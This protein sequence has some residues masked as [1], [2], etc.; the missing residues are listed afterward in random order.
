M[1]VPLGTPPR[2]PESFL[3]GERLPR[4]LDT[5]CPGPCLFREAK[6]ALRRASWGA[7]WSARLDHAQVV[8]QRYAW[9]MGNIGIDIQR[10]ACYQ[11]VNCNGLLSVSEFSRCRTGRVP[12]GGGGVL[13]SGSAGKPSLDSP[14]DRWPT[15]GV[16]S[17]HQLSFEDAARF[18]KKLRSSWAAECFAA[19]NVSGVSL[20]EV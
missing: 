18:S 11:A 5:I 17:R 13:V 15:V 4:I 2:I 1:F 6:F 10:R 8:A 12:R 16:S 3:P 20:G 7:K 9:T 19:Q 14:A